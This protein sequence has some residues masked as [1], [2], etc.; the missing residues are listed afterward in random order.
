MA[1]KSHVRRCVS[2]I[3]NIDPHSTLLGSDGYLA[4]VDLKP[5]LFF[6]DS[7]LWE[8]TA[9]LK[10]Q[11]E[12]QVIGQRTY[13]EALCVVLVHECDSTA[14]SRAAITSVAVDL[15]LGRRTK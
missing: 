5:R 14:G 15:P 13:A 7:G 1:G 12:Q 2:L 4:D 11:V 9:K 6:F 3:S 10:A 8:T